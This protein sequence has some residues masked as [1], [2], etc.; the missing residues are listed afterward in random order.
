MTTKA[1]VIQ[2]KDYN[3]NIVILKKNIISE[4]GHHTNTII[5]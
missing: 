3:K 2:N 5:K 1:P 4:Q